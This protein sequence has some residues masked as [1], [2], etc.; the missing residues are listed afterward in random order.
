MTP[1]GLRIQ[2]LKKRYGSGDTAVDALKGVDMAVAPG[3]VV[4][5]IGESGP[6]GEDSQLPL[7]VVDLN[8]GLEVN[9]SPL[10]YLFL[11]TGDIVPGLSPQLAALV[12]EDEIQVVFPVLGGPGSLPLEEE[13]PLYGLPLLMVSEELIGHCLSPPTAS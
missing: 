11:K 4:G 13:T 3:E 1:R 8:L 9:D 10:L 5:L 12:F 7:L 2:G 6:K